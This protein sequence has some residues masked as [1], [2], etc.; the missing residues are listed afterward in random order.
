MIDR[1]FAPYVAAFVFAVTALGCLGLAVNGVGFTPY[2][3]FLAGIAIGAE[4]DIIGYLIARYF[5]LR[6]YGLL[7]GLMYTIFMLGTSLSQMM[8]S[9]I[10]DTTGSYG[11]YCGLPAGRHFGGAPAPSLRRS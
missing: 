6:S 7:Y 10:F 4:V 5:G 3:A 9:M 1:I 11:V 2:A 8:A